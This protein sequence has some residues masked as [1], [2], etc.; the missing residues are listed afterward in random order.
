MQDLIVLVADDNMKHAMDALLMRHADIG[1]RTID[2]R[3]QVH[4]KRDPGVLR[5]S[6]DLLRVSIRQFRYA[7]AI[8][9]KEGCGKESKPPEDLERLVESSLSANGWEGRSAAIVIDPELEQ[10]IWAGT[11]AVEKA[12]NWPHRER[13]SEWLT[14]T[15][16][17]DHGAVKPRDPKPAFQKAC[18]MADVPRSS[19][20]YA[21][22]AG[23]AHFQDCRD[24][25]F[26]KLLSVLRSWFSSQIAE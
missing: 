18:I 1:I 14:A 3:M 21:K 16:L 4:P 9:D 6:Q 7:I 13:L 26:R 8:L 24:R 5:S 11:E 17:L 19:A 12:L 22:L 20:R 23:I 10:W 2:F 25:A 15:Q